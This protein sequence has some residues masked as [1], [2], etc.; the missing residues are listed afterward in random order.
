MPLEK[1]GVR[2]EGASTEGG[3]HLERGY[4]WRGG[5]LCETSVGRSTRGDGIH[6]EGWC[7]WIWGAYDGCRSTRPSGMGLEAKSGGRRAG[8]WI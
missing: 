7:L 6:C 2:R 5:A 3:V 4:P 1:K 8:V